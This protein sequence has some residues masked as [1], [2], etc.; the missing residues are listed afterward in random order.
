MLQLGS[1]PDEE[2]LIIRTEVPIRPAPLPMITD[3][4]IYEEAE[5][6]SNW[7]LLAQF[8]YGMEG[9]LSAEAEQRRCIRKLLATHQAHD[10]LEAIWKFPNLDRDRRRQLPY[11]SERTS[12][13]VSLGLL[14]A[15][16]KKLYEGPERKKEDAADI[17]KIGNMIDVLVWGHKKLGDNPRKEAER[18]ARL[19]EKDGAEAMIGKNNIFNKS[20]GLT[21]EEIKERHKNPKKARYFEAR[22]LG[23][24]PELAQTWAEGFE[25]EKKRDDEWPL[26]QRLYRNLRHEWTEE[27][28]LAI[29][30]FGFLNF[31]DYLRAEAKI[32]RVRSIHSTS[33]AL[34]QHVVNRDFKEGKFSS[35]QE[36][37]AA[38]ND[39]LRRNSDETRKWLAKC[40]DGTMDNQRFTQLLNFILHEPLLRPMIDGHLALDLNAF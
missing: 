5:R 38:L 33:E 34:Q 17:R 25:D 29:R 21:D 6:T 31:Y 9:Q 14:R 37:E 28:K 10:G 27:Q 36:A 20:R 7:D 8:E 15:D 24:T 4:E 1:L 35:L 22:T 3:A 39:Q 13:L 30:D 19:S 12:H 11:M 18:Y 23:F 32:S 16:E 2:P 40:L 26:S